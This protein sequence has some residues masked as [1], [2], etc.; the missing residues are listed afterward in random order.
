MFGVALV[1]KGLFGFQELKFN[2]HY[3]NILSNA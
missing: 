2:S 1:V 3:I